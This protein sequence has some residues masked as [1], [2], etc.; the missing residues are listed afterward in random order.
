MWLTPA[1]ST[2]SSSGPRAERLPRE[3]DLDLALDERHDLINV[4]VEVRPHSVGQTCC[5]V[6][7]NLAR[8]ASKSDAS[9]PTGLNPIAPVIP[10][11]HERRSTGL[12]DAPV[13]PANGY[14]RAVPQEQHAGSRPSGGLTN[15]SG[16]LGA[17][18]DLAVRLAVRLAAIGA[19]T[20]A[21]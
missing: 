13:D 4:M 18:E 20:S 12:H 11:P 16:T 21:T 10:T 3:G 1:G 6:T 15:P 17:L 19:P 8:Q 5:S 9:E 14:P 2:I 7:S